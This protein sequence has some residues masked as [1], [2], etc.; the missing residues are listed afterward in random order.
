MFSLT[1]LEAT[2]A[3]EKISFIRTPN[4]EGD[5]MKVSSLT[6]MCQ[7]HIL[8]FVIFLP[9]NNQRSGQNLVPTILGFIN[10]KNAL[11]KD[12]RTCVFF[13]NNSMVIFMKVVG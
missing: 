3:M 8:V 13:I 5:Q 11:N 10:D 4:N 6:G 7:E 9:N 12:T 1:T 2:V